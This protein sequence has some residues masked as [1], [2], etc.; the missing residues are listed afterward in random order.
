MNLNN[1]EKLVF[2][3]LKEI[4]FKEFKYDLVSEKLEITRTKNIIFG[5]LTTNIAMKLSKELKKNPLAIAE[6]IKENFK[7]NKYFQ[8]LEVVKPGFV[9]FY[10]SNEFFQ[11]LTK[12]ILK[13]KKF[14]KNNNLEKKEKINFEFISANP[15]GELHIGHV[16]NGLIGDITCNVL[17]YLENKVTRTYYLNDLG[18]QIEILA[19]SVYF[20]Y[21]KNFGIKSKVSAEYNTKE[22]ISYA[23]FLFEKY[24]ESLYSEKDNKKNILKIKDLTLSYFKK[25]LEQI[26]N[27]LGIQK[28]D[29]WY[30]EKEIFNSNYQEKVLEIFK[31]NNFSFEDEGALW[32]KTSLFGDEKDRVLIKA[33]KIQTYFL[34]DIT[35][36]YLKFIDKNK[37]DKV[38]DLFGSD[39]H[40]YQKRMEAAI[41][42]LGFD[43]KKFIIYFIQ[44]VM[45]KDGS[46]KIKMSKRMGTS[47]LAKD[48][49]DILGKDILRFYM[50]DRSREQK[51]ELDLKKIQDESLENPYYNSQYSYARANQIINKVKKLDDLKKIINNKE[52]F[53]S[54][55]VRKIF[56]NFLFLNDSLNTSAKKCEPYILHNILKN[57][58][59]LF[60]KI[61][62]KHKIIVDNKINIDQYN[63]VKAYYLFFELLCYLL[64][65]SPL[66]KM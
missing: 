55:D 54:Q 2:D 61:Y 4:I 5:D 46:N 23:N 32:L 25:R 15:T 37:Y 62:S 59:S 12:E 11:E 47:I 65:I 53:A 3:N 57:S 22:V 35:N 45:L 60:N 66:K 17:E 48:I 52:F 41:D 26:I 10:L 27:E 34:P 18:N 16:R 44:M 42:F 19:N 63:F 14:F 40:G 1:L 49:L 38:I 6:K 9:N 29:I 58:A 33:D 56:L 28:F 13:S 21:L 8:K 50:T 24:G 36:H 7:K 64:G 20:Y 43:H 30:S 31:K 51:L 39:H